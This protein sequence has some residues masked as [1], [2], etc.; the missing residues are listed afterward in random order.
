M[1]MWLVLESCAIGNGDSLRYL[2]GPENE[3]QRLWDVQIHRENQTVFGMTFSVASALASFKRK[4]RKIFL[5]WSLPRTKMRQRM[6]Q[7][8]LWRFDVVLTN[9][10]ITSRQLTKQLDVPE[11][12]VVF[13]PFGVDTDYFCPRSVA[14]ED[15]TD[16]IIPGD[17]FRDEETVESILAN[18]ELRILRLTNRAKIAD[19]YYELE[20]AYPGRVGVALRVPHRELPNL[21]AR[22]RRCLIPITKSSE[23]AGLTCLLES[24]A[25]GVSVLCNNKKTFEDYIVDSKNGF[26]YSTDE[27]L[28]HLL[29]TTDEQTV[30]EM[31][32]NSRQLA[33]DSYCWKKLQATWCQKIYEKR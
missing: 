5:A 28:L 20:Q 1:S 24:M 9:D 32:R 25:C 30:A 13:V 23:P 27:E 11:E 33:V 22:A 17:A 16:L 15:R 4:S 8:L 6:L 3:L 29:E 31:S 19:R 21:Y 18:T 2:D 14:P 26:R 12:K 7:Y 10:T